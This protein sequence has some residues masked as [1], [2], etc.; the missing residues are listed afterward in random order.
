MRLRGRVGRGIYRVE[1]L[2]GAARIVLKRG[3]CSCTTVPSTRVLFP[4]FFRR[5]GP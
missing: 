3:E 5:F 4:A 2:V 1:K